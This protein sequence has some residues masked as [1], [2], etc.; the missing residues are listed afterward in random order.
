MTKILRAALA[1]ASLSLS[2]A[3]PAMASDQPDNVV[4]RGEPAERV[5]RHVRF[6]DLNLAQPSQQRKLG[7]RVSYAV[8]SLCSE[9]TG[10]GADPLL[11]LRCRN[12]AWD[13]ARPQIAQA[14]LRA[15]QLAQT[16]RSDIRIAAID[17]A[18][19]D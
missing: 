4:V 17:L 10:E 2:L 6:A 13:S 11:T 19:R 3:S 12:E 1:A 14:I 5:V 16:G 8:R 15:E 7:A 18:A 9:A